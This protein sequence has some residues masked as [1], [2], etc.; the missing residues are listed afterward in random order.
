MAGYLKSIGGIFA[1]T[2]RY[3]LDKID[4]MNVETKALIGCAGYICAIVLVV[5]GRDKR[6]IDRART[7]GY[8]AG[9]ADGYAA[10]DKRLDLVTQDYVKLLDSMNRNKDA[11]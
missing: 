1:E 10:C 11:W 2:N 9:Y 8:D 6:L 4:S 5:K 7:D 3:I